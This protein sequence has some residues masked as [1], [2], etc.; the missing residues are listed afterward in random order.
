MP[1]VSI[2]I[3]T[4]HGQA[5]KDRIAGRIVDAIAEEASIPREAIWITFQD[6]AAEEWYVAEKSVA[7]IRK[8]AT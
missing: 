5:V 2:R 1:F 3:V 7:A 8:G 6:V 4:G